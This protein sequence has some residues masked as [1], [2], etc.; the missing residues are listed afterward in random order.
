MTFVEDQRAKRELETSIGR[1][2]LARSETRRAMYV[3]SANE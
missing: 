3:K 1:R 2:V